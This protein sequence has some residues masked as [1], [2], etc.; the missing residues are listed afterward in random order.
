MPGFM[1]FK[2][3]YDGFT[4]W[5]A[6]RGHT[7][8]KFWRPSATPRL[9]RPKRGRPAEYN[10]EGVKTRL[11][12]CASQHGPVRSFTELLQICSNIASELHPSNSTPDDSTIRAAIK[13]YGL[14]AAASLVPGK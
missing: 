5:I 2:L 9:K 4:G 10:W 7:K 11:V 3:H 6:E 14:E 12:T 8:P 1:C 13:K